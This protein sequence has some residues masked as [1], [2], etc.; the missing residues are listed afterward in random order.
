MNLYV[1]LIPGIKRN[2]MQKIY[3][4]SKMIRLDP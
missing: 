3:F 1:R 4:D 2:K